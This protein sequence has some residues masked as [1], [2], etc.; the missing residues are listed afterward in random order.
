[1]KYLYSYN[2]PEIAF[3][4]WV[5][6]YPFSNHPL[7]RQRFYSFIQ[8]VHKYKR[9]GNRWRKKEYFIKRIRDYGFRQNEAELVAKFEE[10]IAILDFLESD[11]LPV[12]RKQHLLRN[13]FANHLS[14]YIAR[15]VVNNK[16]L[17]L[18]ISKNDYDGGKVN[19]NTFK[20]QS[21]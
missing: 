9:Q 1:M 10:M 20:K 7:D 15:A 8:T 16:L 18:D 3:H 19:K 17:L 6:N 21:N 2:P 13:E 5:S 14:D 12:V 11:H 4:I